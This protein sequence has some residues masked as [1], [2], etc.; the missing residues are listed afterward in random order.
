MARVFAVYVVTPMAVPPPTMS[1]A[2]IAAAMSLF[3]RVQANR[4]LA[5][6][7]SGLFSGTIALSSGPTYAWARSLR[8]L[9][10]VRS[11]T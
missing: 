5:D 6:A 7:G 4:D 2:D 11:Q 1:T 10:S 8:S 9:G 3:F